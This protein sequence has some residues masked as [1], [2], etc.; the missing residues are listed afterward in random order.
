MPAQHSTVTTGCLTLGSQAESC[1]QTAAVPTLKWSKVSLLDSNMSSAASPT[2]M[3]LY[4]QI[5]CSQKLDGSKVQK[6]AS[7]GLLNP[8][9]GSRRFNMQARCHHD[10][11]K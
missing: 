9:D 8:E 4:L 5:Y 1:C 10:S 11:T 3:A 7:C 2:W 6:R